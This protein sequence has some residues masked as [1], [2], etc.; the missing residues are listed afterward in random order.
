MKLAPDQIRTLKIAIKRVGE[1]EFALEENGHHQKNRMALAD[2]TEGMLSEVLGGLTSWARTPELMI[3]T[4]DGKEILVFEADGEL[5]MSEPLE[6][7]P[8]PDEEWVKLPRAVQT[9][10]TLASD[11][12]HAAWSLN[13]SVVRQSELKEAIRQCMKGVSQVLDDIG[14][15]GIYYLSDTEAIKI[16]LHSSLGV[17][18]RRWSII[19]AI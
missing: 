1:A 15:E 2:E 3:R 11:L 19:A 17:K 4:R 10:K 13:A 7:D 6:G 12:A 16:Y 5:Q 14:C 9:V 18:T 8:I